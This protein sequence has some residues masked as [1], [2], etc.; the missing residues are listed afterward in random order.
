MVVFV[1]SNILCF[2][3]MSHECCLK[4]GITCSVSQD[5]K[6]GTHSSVR[7]NDHPHNAVREEQVTVL[8]QAYLD[9]P[10]LLHTSY[11]HATTSYVHK[12]CLHQ[13]FRNSFQ[14]HTKGKEKCSQGDISTAQKHLGKADIT[15]LEKGYFT[16]RFHSLCKPY[17][18]IFFQSNCS[19]IQSFTSGFWLLRQLLVAPLTVTYQAPLSMGFPRQEYWSG[20]PFPSPGNLPDP[21]IESR[22]PALLE[23]SLLSEPPGKPRVLVLEFMKFP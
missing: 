7:S 11:I 5:T 21:G 19:L 23:D 10:R 17:I 2:F 14:Y 15:S 13:G 4:V 6:E 18:S 22:F 12:D 9:G 8:H 16:N 1:S 3:N 20:L